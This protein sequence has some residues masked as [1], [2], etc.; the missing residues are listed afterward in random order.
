MLQLKN[1][2]QQQRR[3]GKTKQNNKNI[4]WDYSISTTGYCST[5]TCGGIGNEFSIMLTESC[6]DCSTADDGV[7]GM[8]TW[9]ACDDSPAANPSSNRT[10][11]LAELTVVLPGVLIIPGGR[12]SGVLNFD[13]FGTLN[14][15]SVPFC[16]FSGCILKVLDLFP[17][18]SA[19][20]KSDT[21][22][23]ASH[24]NAFVSTPLQYHNTRDFETFDLY[25]V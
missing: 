11:P 14:L 7:S 16:Y 10:R 8:T 6:D 21:V 5:S 23:S 4:T 13:I 19:L 17:E 9:V 18:C 2:N 3:Y 12:M 25:P 20:C 22:C 1:T 15:I 24:Y